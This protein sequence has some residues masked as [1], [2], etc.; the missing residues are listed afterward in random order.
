MPSH[1]LLPAHPQLDAVILLARAPGDGHYGIAHLGS[2]LDGQV[3][4][5]TNPVRHSHSH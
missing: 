3:P 4:Q 2:V 1:T 5:S